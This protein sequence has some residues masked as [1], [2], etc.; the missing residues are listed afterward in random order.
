MK[1]KFFSF[2]LLLTL[3]GCDDFTQKNLE[4]A[5]PPPR[6][7]V[8]NI[9]LL[10][11]ES[12]TINSGAFSL[13]KLIANTGTFVTGPLVE[14]FKEDAKELDS[15][16]KQ[17]CQTLD[18]LSDLSEEQLK[19]LRKP[20]QE[21]WKDTM[22]GYHKL[23]MMEFGP[24]ASLLTAPLQAIYS[25]ERELKCRVDLTLIQLDRGGSE[26][27]PR[28]DV[29]DNYNV[30]GLDTIEAL[31][32]TGINEA[33]CERTQ[34]PLSRWFK[35][36]ILEREKQICL[37][38]SHLSG[39]IVEKANEMQKGWSPQQGHYTAQM[40]RAGAPIEKTNEISQALFMLDTNTKDLKLSYP[41]GFEVKL[42]NEQTKCPEASC[43]EAREHPYAEFGL[44]ALEA[45]LEG[46]QLL[47]EGR[48][49]ETGVN[50]MGFDDL[51]RD[52]DYSDLANSMLENTNNILKKVREL[53]KEKTLGELLTGIDQTACENTTSDNR[54][55]EV[56]ALVWDIRSVSNLLKFDYLSA[57]QELSAPGQA[58]GDND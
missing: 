17:Y 43:P 31:Y 49:F 21:N 11:S 3:F 27:L 54:L 24:Q 6:E 44:D 13:D 29:V 37:Y 56:C 2:T 5:T 38:A 39:H 34:R 1:I 15:S 50:G 4:S 14:A 35:K 26:R 7:E 41:A 53:K 33:R 58:Q 30:R 9:D 51:L 45:S 22:R 32:F 20:I 36:P 8:Q 55:V 42:G 52:R 23:A 48:G 25:F 46:F 57:L 12:S 47:F 28:L 40:L 10:L 19:N 18:V 16:I